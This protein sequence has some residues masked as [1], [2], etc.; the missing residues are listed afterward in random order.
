MKIAYV[1]SPDFPFD[2]PRPEAEAM[3]KAGIAKPWVEVPS[4]RVPVSFWGVGNR[5]VDN[6]PY[7]SASCNN[8]GNKV[9]FTGPTAHRTQQF[10]HCGVAE[11]APEHLQEEYLRRREIWKRPATKPVVTE[12]PFFDLKH[13]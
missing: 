8:C 5:D 6:Q 2:K 12:V 4:V 11:N 13:F 3:I 1:A 10:R 7:I 9:Q